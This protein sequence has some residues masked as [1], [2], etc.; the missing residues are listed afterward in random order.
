MN[1]F[2]FR[3]IKEFVELASTAG[4]QYLENLITICQ[5]PSK[6]VCSSFKDK[7]P[8]LLQTMREFRPCF[9]LCVEPSQFE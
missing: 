1:G 7:F 3:W 4:T 6:K 5:Q 2:D 9:Y 8:L